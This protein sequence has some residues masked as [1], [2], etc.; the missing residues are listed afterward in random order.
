MVVS[1]LK[2]YALLVCMQMPVFIGLQWKLFGAE[3]IVVYMN[4]I[5]T[6]Q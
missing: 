3:I 6:G 2:A 5:V 4:K 1:S